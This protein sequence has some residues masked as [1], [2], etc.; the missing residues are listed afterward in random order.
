MAGPIANHAPAAM[1]SQP[2]SRPLERRELRSSKRPPITAT[3]P[4]TM[5]SQSLS[6]V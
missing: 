1:P 3:A 4:G 2:P 6:E 5:Q